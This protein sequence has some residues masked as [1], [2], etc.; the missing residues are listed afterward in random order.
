MSCFFWNVRGFNK[1]LKHS[2]VTEWVNRR[3]MKF[4]CILESRVKEGKAGRILNKVFRDWSSITNYEDSSGGRIWLIW[5]NE[6]RMTPV[7]KSDQIITCSVELKGEAEFYC[8]CIYASNQVDERK[9]LWEDLAYHHKSP[10]FKN[11]AWIIMGD[12]MK[13]LKEE[14]VQGL[15]T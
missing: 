15:I 3:E 11:K 2:V 4:G 14:R 9:T 7:Y 10:I 12:L 6:I 1:D 8:S 5:R 13:L